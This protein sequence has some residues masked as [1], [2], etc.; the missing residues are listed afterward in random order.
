MKKIPDLAAIAWY[1]LSEQE[2]PPWDEKARIAKAEHRTRTLKR[3]VERDIYQGTSTSWLVEE[4]EDEPYHPPL[5]LPPELA[6]GTIN[7]FA[8]PTG[9]EIPYPTWVGIVPQ[10]PSVRTSQT[11]P[12]FVSSQN[13]Q[14]VVPS[15]SFSYF[16]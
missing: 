3:R 15:Q 16:F 12:R 10:F 5:F 6:Q 11:E 9:F 7:N 2:K 1:Q 14:F 8:T 13:P 4:L